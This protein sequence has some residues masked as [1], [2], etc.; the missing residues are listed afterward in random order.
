MHI[1]S[2][3]PGV[4]SG[5]THP[6]LGFDAIMPSG[7]PLPDTTTLDP[8]RMQRES[9]AHAW[10]VLLPIRRGGHGTRA[11]MQTASA[12]ARTRVLPHHEAGGPMQPWLPLRQGRAHPTPPHVV[13]HPVVLTHAA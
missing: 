10:P 3:N 2:D 13:V 1:L 4:V 5:V 6:P 8:T 7:Q 9:R 11:V 12:S